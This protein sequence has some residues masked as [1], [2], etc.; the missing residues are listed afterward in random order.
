MDDEPKKPEHCIEGHVET[1]YDEFYDDGDL[2]ETQ[3]EYYE[4]TKW[5]PGY[6]PIMTERAHL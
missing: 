6:P 2:V 3:G 4:C 1:W 5:E